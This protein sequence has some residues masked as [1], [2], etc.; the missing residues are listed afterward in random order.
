MKIV[1][2]QLLILLVWTIFSLLVLANPSNILVFLAP[3]A[4]P[5]LSYS[6]PPLLKC[7]RERTIKTWAATTLMSESDRLLHGNQSV[8]WNNLGSR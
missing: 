4:R 3:L 7:V 5:F 6:L 8:A 2:F 1:L